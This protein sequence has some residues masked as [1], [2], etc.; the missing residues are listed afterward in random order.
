[1]NEVTSVRRRTMQAVRSKDTK[2][3][4]ALRRIVSA[5]GYRYRLHRRDLPGT[6]DLAFISRK[7]IICHNGCFWHGHSCQRGARVPK[8]N[9][10]YWVTKIARNRARD[11]INA[12]ALRKIGWRALVVWECELRDVETLR[13]RISAFL[14]AARPTNDG[15]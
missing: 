6:P 1:M 10:D 11:T 13:R 2:P 12:N 14:G 8:T 5:L 3:E 9:Q 15:H 4:L 7:L